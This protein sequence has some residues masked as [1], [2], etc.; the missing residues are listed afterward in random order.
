[1]LVD[2]TRDSEAI[3]VQQSRTNTDLQH[4]LMRT[5][6]LPVGRLLPRF[7]RIVRQTAR[8][9]GKQIRLEVKGDD[10]RIDRA[11]LN[12][13]VGPLEHILR[14]AVDHGVEAPEARETKQKDGEGIVR[15]HVS[16]D[17]PEVVIHIDDD[18]QGVSLDAVRSRA[19]QRELLQPG[20][21]LS[22]D[23]LLQL[24][25]EPGFSTGRAVT[26]ISG[27]GVG[28]D[29]VQNEVK[30]LGGSVRAES[31]DGTGASF[32]IRLPLTLAIN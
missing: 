29:V 2:L 17:G 11:I 8:E 19:L 9:L 5:R 16:R 3:L 15:L 27:R 10:I 6:M 21:E 4:G 32:V 24:I 20:A 23:A 26:Q 12:R 25:F 18:G 7:R 31:T 1:M 30:Q 22:V 13:M 14:N 28:L